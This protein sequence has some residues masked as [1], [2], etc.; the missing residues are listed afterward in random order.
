MQLDEEVKRIVIDERMRKI[1]YDAIIAEEEEKTRVFKFKLDEEE[2]R[3]KIED[4]R[5]RIKDNGIIT[6]GVI[7]YENDQSRLRSSLGMRLP[8]ARSNRSDEKT[9][10]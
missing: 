8:W 4:G 10:S 9:L 6:D 3:M 5:R 7:P 1:K 2:K